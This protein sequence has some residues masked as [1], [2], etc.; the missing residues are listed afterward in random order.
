MLTK[1]TIIQLIKMFDNLKKKLG[2]IVSRITQRPNL[3]ESDVKNALEE[4]RVALLEADVALP[5]VEKFLEDV[6]RKAIGAQI[7][8]SVRAG[9][10]VIKIVHD[11]LQN[12]M[13]S[14][15]SSLNLR[16][17]PPAVIMMVG[18]QGSGKT[19][20]AAKI[21]MYLKKKLNKKVLLA[22]L[23]TYR[24]AAQE[25]LEILGKSCEIDTLPI[26]A[27]QLPLEISKRAIKGAA[28]FD[29]LILDTAG[30]LHTD[31][32]MMEE[33]QHIKKMSKPV[34]VLLAVDALTGQDAANIGKQFSEN[35]GVTGIVMT[36]VD[37]DARGG[38]ALSMRMITGQPIKFIGTGERVEELEEFHPE[39]ITSNILGFGDIVGLVEKAQEAIEEEEAK[40]VAAKMQK[41]LFDLQDLYTQLKSMKKMGGIAS[42]MKM[43]PG[44][45]GRIESALSKID[46]DEQV[47]RQMSIIES[48]TIKERRFPAI[49]NPSR[50]K[51]IA[52]GSG[53]QIAHV[54]SVLKK[55]EDMVKMMKKLGKVS[56]A[57]I[58]KLEKMMN[59]RP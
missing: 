35:V 34:E 2:N 27:G 12:I 3:S 11:E 36:R 41:G 48:M 49:I 57:D 25:Q 33:L 58:A 29:V 4:V 38:A 10:M 28:G 6:S 16:S 18:L 23:D 31:A 1:A 42:L 54:N 52:A 47:K 32:Q 21:G 20:S 55:Y 7:T 19:T 14:E 17:Q 56:P 5:V 59:L 39:R 24:P 50:K 8:K 37:S 51:R 15:F 45:G 30:R 13:G 9:H 40:R 26:Q 44:M 22:S 46:V 53:T 43:M